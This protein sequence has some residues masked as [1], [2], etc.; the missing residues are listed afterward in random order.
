LPDFYH[1][2]SCSLCDSKALVLRL[3][4]PACPP[5][6]AFR[7]KGHSQHKGSYFPMDLYQCEDCG[8]L[9]L[10]D[11]ISPKLLFGDYI[12]LSSSSPD[13]NKHFENYSNFM[14]E[15]FERDGVRKRFCV[16][17]GCNDGLFLS[18]IARF[19]HQ[20]LGVDASEYCAKVSNQNGVSCVQGFFEPTLAERLLKQHGCADVIFANNVF[21]HSDHLI[22]ILEGVKTLLSDTGLFVFEVSYALDTIDQRVFDYI[23]HEHVG[24][25]SLKPL[26]KFLNKNGFEIEDVVRVNT[27]G[28]S[29]RVVAKKIAQDS[30]SPQV[31][32]PQ[33]VKELLALEEKSGLYSAKLYK[34]LEDF[35]NNRR[36][37]INRYISEALAS[38]KTICV[39]GASATSIVLMRSL[40]LEGRVAFIVDDNS[41]R[42]GRLA[43]VGDIPVVSR[44]ALGSGEEFL[45]VVLAWRFW[46]RIVRQTDMDESKVTF[47]LPMNGGEVVLQQGYAPTPTPRV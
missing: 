47:L 25:H 15:Y 41:L 34:D 1:R 40:D 23:Y 42:Q 35:V 19:G 14:Q 5:V 32:Q 38:G 21:S 10:L 31:V 18:K 36:T 27:K 17:V 7:Y 20:V 26:I 43:P 16:D 11:I 30:S 45:C 2:T 6:D 39:Y 24:Y 29:I 22:E 13:L 3:P 4:M 44:S 28:G 9:Q 33:A 37:L 8:Y 12:Y 46:N